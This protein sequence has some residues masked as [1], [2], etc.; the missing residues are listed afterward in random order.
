MAQDLDS[1]LERLRQAE[2]RADE[3]R[4]LREQAEQRLRQTGQQLERNTLFGLLEKCHEL[5]LAIRI[6]T[7]A[8]LTTQGDPSNPINRRRPKRLV[9]WD[10]FPDLQ[11]AVWETFY[12]ESDFL[13]NRLFAS[14]HQL[15]LIQRD[16]QTIRSEMDLRF[17]ERDT[18]DRFV[19]SIL[20]EI[21]NN[22][23]LREHFKLRGNVTFES[24]ANMSDVTSSLEDTME[25]LDIAKPSSRLNATPNR[26]RSKRPLA[27]RRN[28][29]ADQFC[30]HV[31]SEEQRIPVYAVENYPVNLTAGMDAIELLQGYRG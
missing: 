21:G 5:S 9:P 13:S 26:A 4:R 20:N 8:T 24:H 27:R 3:E 1:L 6:E 16:I 28:R 17:F 19:R 2:Q 14:R 7:N 31:I 12:T 23:S 22:D 30:V 10:E 11:E 18:V 25:Q 15:Q 29:R